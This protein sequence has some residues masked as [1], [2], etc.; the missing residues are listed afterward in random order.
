MLQYKNLSAPV[1]EIFDIK[2]LAKYYALID[3]TQ[4]YHGFTWHNS[5]RFE[6]HSRQLLDL[7]L[8]EPGQWF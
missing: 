2:K 8:M 6:W 7:G 4:A 1:S 3:I 5:T